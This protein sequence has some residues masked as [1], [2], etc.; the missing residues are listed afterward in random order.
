MAISSIRLKSQ[1]GLQLW[2]T[3]MMMWLS[4]ALGETINVK[5]SAKE[6]LGYS[7]LKYIV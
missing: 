1:L 3:S 5:I 2:K 4:V 7:E 6:S